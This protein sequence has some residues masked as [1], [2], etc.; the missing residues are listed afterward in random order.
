MV[1]DLMKHGSLFGAAALALLSTSCVALAGGP[2][3]VPTEAPVA[4]QVPDDA[5]DW[6]GFWVGGGLGYGSTNYE[7]SGDAE[8]SEVQ[9]GSLNLPDL[10]GQGAFVSLEAGYAHALAPK[11]ILAGQLDYAFG[12][13]GNDADLNLDGRPDLDASYDLKVKSMLAGTARLGYLPSDATMVYGLAGL[14]RAEF[15]ADYS[16]S[17]GEMSSQGGYDFSDTGLTIGAGIE[18]RLNE[19]VGLKFEYRYT[20]FDD[21]SLYEDSGVEVSA[22]NAIQSV[23]ASLTYRF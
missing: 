13:I 23:N 19:K 14:T 22:D 11:W 8:I 6:S 21:Y 16:L 18:T 4:V 2:V 1:K 20:K 9:S 17:A 12:D 3:E 7:I 5:H 10:G 15:E